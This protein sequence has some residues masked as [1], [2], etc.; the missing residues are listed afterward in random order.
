VNWFYGWDLYFAR[1]YDKAI[2]QVRKTIDLD[3]NYWFAHMLLG[4]VYEQKGRL[5]EAI[6]ELEKARSLEENI[7]SVGELGRA[8]AVAGKRSDARK[9]ANTLEEQW[10]RTHLGAYDVLIIYAALGEKDQAFAWLERAYEDRTFFLAPLKVNP[11]MDPLRSDPRFQDV[12]RRMNFP[13]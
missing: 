2:E 10:K 5:S 3:P 4:C 7:Q 9:L 8:Y 6:Q 13:Q 12:L 1:R 11:E